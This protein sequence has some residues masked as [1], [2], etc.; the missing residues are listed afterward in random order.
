[1]RSNLDVLQTYEDKVLDLS[2]RNRLLRF[3]K[4]ARSIIFSMDLDE[5]QE[6]FGIPEELNI[7]FNHKDIL[8]DEIVQQKLLLEP[9]KTEQIL[10]EE[11]TIYIPLTKPEGQKLITSLNA[12]RLDT[13]RKFEEHGLHT[14]F[15]AIGKIKWNE[16]SSYKNAKNKD[17][18]GDDFDYVAPMILIPVQISERKIPK[19]TVI[20][21][22]LETNDI[23]FNIALNLLL[24]KEHGTRIIKIN[25]ELVSDISKLFDD[26]SKQLKEVFEE[27]KVS[28]ELTSEIQ[29]GQYTFY[30]Q[31]IYEDLVN[32]EEEFLQNEFIN[33]LCTHTPLNQPNL[34][35]DIDDTNNFLSLD[36]DYNVMDADTSQIQ[37]VQNVLSGNHLNIQGPPGTGK[38]QTIVNIIS[39]FLA[40]N[41][42]VLL[43]CEK[44]VALEVVLNRLR[45]KGLDKLCLPLFQYNEDKKTFA[46]KV[47][48]DRDFVSRL[49]Y[50]DVELNNILISREKKITDLKNY[51][52]A[53][54]RIVEP[55]HKNTYWVHGEFS[56]QL[57]LIK[58]E[59]LTSELLW[60]S[61]NPLEIS[62]EEYQEMMSLLDNMSSVFNLPLEDKHMHWEK[63]NKTVYSKDLEGKIK[64]CLLKLINLIEK[65]NLDSKYFSIKSIEEFKRYIS[66]LDK[67]E[68]VN[69]NIENLNLKIEIDTIESTF[70]NT[71]NS[72][73]KYIK[74]HDSLKKE[75]KVPIHWGQIVKD[76]LDKLILDKDIDLSD[77]S[78][79]LDQV[80][81]ITFLINTSEKNLSHLKSSEF[82]TKEPL[83]EVVFNK[84]NIG[85]LLK[86]SKL[87]DWNMLEQ[88]NSAMEQLEILKSLDLKLKQ[89]KL[90]FSKWGLITNS[91]DKEIKEYA[92]KFLDAYRNPIKRIP[93]ISLLP[94]LN[95]PDYSKDKIRIEEIAIIGKPSN[96]SEYQEI[97]QAIKDWFLHQNKLEL[98]T[99]NFTEE[100]L[101]KGA[102]INREEIE[103]LLS[104]TE[105]VIKYLRSENKKELSKNLTSFIEKNRGDIDVVQT[106]FDKLLKVQE[107]WGSMRDLY[108]ENLIDK[109]SLSNLKALLPQAK[110]QLETI[111]TLNDSVKALVKEKP[112]KIN[113]LIKDVEEIN[114]L[115][116]SI[117]EIKKNNFDSIYLSKNYIEFMIYNFDRFALLHKNILFLKK[118]L[119]DIGIK[120]NQT[121]LSLSD[122][123]KAIDE[124]K[125]KVSP[126]IKWVE[127]YDSV[128]S[129]LNKLFNASDSITDIENLSFKD[130]VKKIWQMLNDGEGLEKWIIYRRYS[131]LV[132]SKGF[133]EFLKEAR[134]TH[135]DNPA[136]LFATTL[137][138]AWLENYYESNSVLRDFQVTDHE[139]LIREFRQLD[140]QTLEINSHRILNIASEYI[141]KAKMQSGW[142]DSELI[143][144]SQLK[145]RHKPIRK[146]V[147]SNGQQIL[148]YKR[149]W[150]MSP[151]TLSS[152]IPFQVINFDVV[153]FDEASQMR[154]EHAL[155]S[156]ARAK[157][158]VIFGD[159]N[160]LPPTPFF[161]VDNSDDE[162]EEDEDY[163][164]I[165]NATKEILPNAYKMLEYHYRSKYEDLI[166]FSNW[167]IY[168]DR[169][170]TFPNPVR[171][172]NKI[173]FEYVKDGVFDGGAAGTRKNMVEAK[174]VAELCIKQ[175]VDEPEKSLGVIAF[176]KSQEEAIREEVSK[177]LESWPELKS[178]LD[179]DSEKLEKFF[180]KNL[181]S[182]QG[183]E[184]DVIIISLGYGKDKNERMHQRFGPINS[185]KGFRRLNVAVTRA[186]HKVICV[187]SIKATDIVNA[188]KASRGVFLL[189]KYLDYAENGRAAIDAPKLRGVHN[190][191]DFA[192][193][194]EE[195]VARAIEKL[196]YTVDNQVGASGYKIDL[197]IV[198]PDNG[199]EY[200]LGIECDGAQ[201]H[202]SYSARVNDR[203]RGENLRDR[204][205]EIFRIWSQHWIR[206]R[207]L[208]MNSL[209]SKLAE[210]HSLKNNK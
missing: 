36:T 143:H 9:E 81:R 62:F 12:L 31:Q 44:H 161:Q 201:Y 173:E 128:G 56:K 78:T 28:Y 82:I 210:L 156:I 47:I 14:L 116:R 152:Y 51:A 187:S 112:Q 61:K 96:F 69:I 46:K 179:E 145:R 131:Q 102:S 144:Q 67:I 19:K 85:A 45:E 195:E 49:K 174:K 205:W 15:I 13:K 185:Q 92:E 93:F 125:I 77:L 66:Y 32:N 120:N 109:E 86:V 136:S 57:Q 72:V 147:S 50:D 114:Q 98:L 87:K 25:E 208:I 35:I 160:Q 42:S 107:I 121:N 37:V 196:G 64:K 30:G 199:E 132:E 194:F 101:I 59:P 110:E 75:Y 182:V 39:N 197:A 204:G 150:M 142:K 129:E 68:E 33:A 8:K 43:I 29:V 141:R 106:L 76:D 55:L 113:D 206:H 119:E 104:S 183:D 63:I 138:N 53:L 190:N 4:N 16:K 135:V 18:N 175:A 139:R 164:S 162:E 94:F 133:S 73:Y 108:K 89:V 188:D 103:S 2:R 193:P 118:L 20:N 157:Q 71:L 117:E 17:N 52:D 65:L 123:I 24:A 21:T 54:C 83:N 203:I 10:E 91:L 177:E 168:D 115:Y 180:I 100:Y 122:G 95:L 167:Y 166:A 80:V 209:V 58:L 130:A 26:V 23:S 191:E 149:C 159:E 97:A 5:F 90:I 40:G 1:M 151:L 186:K 198:N 153:I 79:I 11:E 3:P 189:Q 38:S 148:N 202:S 178:I 84:E 200:I 124:L 137:W 27:I 126:L 127:S 171:G 34:S 176:S 155:G 6:K 172:K 134:L 154:V 111:I 184:R 60:S 158:V 41:K 163:E 165:L 207:E 192:S 181:E 48:D 70:T 7:E 105:E 146:L 74:T 22:Y 99:K 169:L 170:I 140:N 88:L